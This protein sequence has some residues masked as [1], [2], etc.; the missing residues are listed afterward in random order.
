MT[1]ITAQAA[2]MSHKRWAHLLGFHEQGSSLAALANY[3][4]DRIVGNDAA[5]I[6]PSHALYLRCPLS[7][8]SIP[9][10]FAGRSPTSISTLAQNYGQMLHRGLR[11]LP[12][13]IDALS[14]PVRLPRVVVL[15][16][17]YDTEESEPTYSIPD[18]PLIS[19]IPSIWI[20]M[21]FPRKVCVQLSNPPGTRR[22]DPFDLKKMTDAVSDLDIVRAMR[23]RSDAHFSPSLLACV[24]AASSA[25]HRPLSPLATRSLDGALLFNYNI[26]PSSAR[27]LRRSI[28][29]VAQPQSA[30]GPAVGLEMIGVSTVDDALVRAIAARCLE[31]S[32][33]LER[34]L[35]RVTLQLPHA[36]DVLVSMA[37]S[38][39]EPQS[40][41]L[42]PQPP[43][44]SDASSKAN[45][46]AFPV[47]PPPEVTKH[48]D[49]L[50][51]PPSSAVA[52]SVLPQALVSMIATRLI[53]RPVFGDAITS[54]EHSR[55]RVDSECP[56]YNEVGR[57]LERATMFCDRVHEGEQQQYGLLLGDAFALKYW[58][59]TLP[60]PL[61]ASA[62]R[63]RD[64]LAGLSIEG[65]LER[66]EAID[67]PRERCV[68]MP[69]GAAY[70]VRSQPENSIDSRS[71]AYV[72]SLHEMREAASTWDE[73]PLWD[74]TEG[75]YAYITHRYPGTLAAL[76]GPG[77]LIRVLQNGRVCAVRTARGWLYRTDPLANVPDDQWSRLLHG[78]VP[79]SG[80]ATPV[81]KTQA[82]TDV[83][84]FRKIV[85]ILTLCAE[86][87]SSR[88][89]RH[90][91][92]GFF[93]W[94]RN[95][96]DAR[97]LAEEP[98]QRTLREDGKSVDV[99]ILADKLHQSELRRLG[100][101]DP[102]W[103]TGR[104]LRQRDGTIDVRTA[105]V[106]VRAS[107]KDGAIILGG[108][109]LEVV[110]YARR[111]RVE[112]SLS[113]HVIDDEM[114]ALNMTGTKRATAIALARAL[115]PG[116]IAI[117]VSSDG[118]IRFYMGAGGSQEWY[119]SNGYHT[120]RTLF[121][122]DV[123]EDRLV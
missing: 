114:A 2:L 76:A 40:V 48:L 89:R 14:Y 98:L 28:T 71:V 83:E 34:L 1:L 112:P 24:A 5:R 99:N 94:L 84:E 9:I 36:L 41:P 95:L 106:I 49:A 30:L 10:A 52:R 3:I 86:Q 19:G 109:E 92:G 47:E 107:K 70:N 63:V 66:F 67:D 38:S 118:P 39:H 79:A 53:A 77:Q 119:E 58:P 80:E 46:E 25:L 73:L 8:D 61:Q 33:W 64:D 35:F 75:L 29:V 87:T 68:V 103:L 69:Y 81:A 6:G 104:T 43:G 57:F 23:L 44:A 110:C 15:D 51:D 72:I 11:P 121:T 85:S 96:D 116:T 4:N 90:A 65:M 82:M 32:C 100:T 115:G 26:F 55:C 20:T 117:A 18:T 50:Y 62:G 93:L 120:K 31:A 74:H 111:I 60:V 91:H 37:S 97:I 108:K 45:T 88:S 105:R 59:G 21:G 7:S 42:I 113:S 13:V 122:G 17:S 16:A 12:M 56:L 78:S 123:E 22:R 54:L 101:G 27:G 102:K